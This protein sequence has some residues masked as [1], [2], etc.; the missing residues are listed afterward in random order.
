MIQLAFCFRNQNS[1]YDRVRK[2]HDN[3]VRCRFRSVNARPEWKTRSALA[4]PK[5]KSSKFKPETFAGAGDRDGL[6]KGAFC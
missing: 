4:E 2:V 6:E 1:P 3:L 5:T